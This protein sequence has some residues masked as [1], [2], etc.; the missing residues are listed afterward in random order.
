MNTNKIRFDTSA[1]RARILEKYDS[2]ESFAKA[3][4]MKPKTLLSRLDNHSDFYQYEMLRIRS[5]LNLTV[6]EVTIMFFTPEEAIPE[7]LAQ[8]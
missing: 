7:A 4:R 8:I 5:A 1:L 3:V 6:E 2:I